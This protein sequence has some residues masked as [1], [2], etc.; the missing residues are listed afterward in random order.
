MDLLEVFAFFVEVVQVLL[1]N[2]E[3]HPIKLLIEDGILVQGATSVQPFRLLY[4]FLGLEKQFHI[5]VGGSVLVLVLQYCLVVQWDHFIE[6][7]LAQ[8]SSVFLL[9]FAEELSKLFDI[10]LVEL[11]DGDLS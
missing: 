3:N 10:L 6:Q 7:Q 9:L 4:L 1:P 5:L 11:L 8:H 2:L